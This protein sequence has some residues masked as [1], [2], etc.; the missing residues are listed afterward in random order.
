MSNRTE[1]GK[2]LQV[3]IDSVIGKDSKAVID[4]LIAIATG[5][6]TVKEEGLDRHGN[7]EITESGASAAERI[8]AADLLLS[9][10]HGPPEKTINHN[11]SGGPAKWDPDKLSLD[12]LNQLHKLM[13]KG[14]V[15]PEN[16]VEGGFTEEDDDKG[17]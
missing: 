1:T 10:Q 16:V 3:Y 8:R 15:L 14:R 4:E 13:E 12:E 17:E 6:R 7:P 9:Y 2:A 5:K 11:V